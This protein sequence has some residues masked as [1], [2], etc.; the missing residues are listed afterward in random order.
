MLTHGPCNVDEVLRNFLR[1]ALVNC[2][3]LII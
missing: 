3:I 1:N 2:E